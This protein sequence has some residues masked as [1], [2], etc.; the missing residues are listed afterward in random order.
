MR[1]NIFKG[2][3]ENLCHKLDLSREC[4][5][6]LIN[7]LFS[8]TQYDLKEYYDLKEE[9][10]NYNT[11]LNKFSSIIGQ[12]EDTK[13]IKDVFTISSDLNIIP[14][15]LLKEIKLKNVAVFVG[16][17][18]SKVVSDKYPLWDELANKSIKYLFNNRKIN[19]FEK[20]RLIREISDPKQKLS[21]FEKYIGGKT[22]EEYKKFLNQNFNFKN[23]SQPSKENPYQILCSENYNFI[24]VT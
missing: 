24:K 10:Y 4:K 22:D 19:F 2:E 16:A 18:L 3:F 23:E 20:E 15:E 1:R 13:V 9:Y 17:G 6:K 14:E 8:G 5:F 7:A 11:L 21:I 12:V